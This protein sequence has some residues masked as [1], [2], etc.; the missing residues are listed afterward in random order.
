[1]KPDPWDRSG[2]PLAFCLSP[3]LLLNR[4]KGS[5]FQ[6]GCCGRWTPQYWQVQ[7]TKDLSPH[8]QSSP[9]MRSNNLYWLA[10]RPWSRLTRLERQHGWYNKPSYTSRCQPWKSCRNTALLKSIRHDRLRR[11]I[12][13]PARLDRLS[14][15]LPNAQSGQRL[16]L[17]LCRLSTL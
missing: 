13:R 1:M 14:R 2:T 12:R 17:L 8:S 6:D 15:Q 7:P 5:D 16:F 10:Q 11:L 9:R 3:R 4:L